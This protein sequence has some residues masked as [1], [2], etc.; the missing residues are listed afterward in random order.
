MYDIIATDLKGDHPLIDGLP[1]LEALPI[2]GSGIPLSRA[3]ALS[4]EQEQIIEAERLGMGSLL[5][6]EGTTRRDVLLQMSWW[7]DPLPEP[8]GL[9]LFD[10]GGVVVKD[11]NMLGKIAGL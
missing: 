5:I 4:R 3:L 2:E 10:L 6:D 9:V 8:L 1:H 7:D 11:I